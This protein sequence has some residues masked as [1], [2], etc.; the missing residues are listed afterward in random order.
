[1]NQPAVKHIV[2]YLYYSLR[3]PLCQGLMLNYLKDLRSDQTVFHLITFEQEKFSMSPAEAS[4][5]RDQL[6]SGFNIEWHPL[7]YSSGSFFLMKKLF[8]A[9]KA[10]RLLKKIDGAHQ[11]SLVCAM[12]TPVGSY[13]FIASRLYHKKFCQFTFEPHAQIMMESGRISSAGLKYRIGHWLEMMIG[14]NAETVVCTT[15]HMVDNLQKLG[16]KGELFRLPTSVDEDKNRFSKAGRDRLRK[17]L[18]I[19][20]K[21]VLIYP[22]KFGGMYAESKAI[23]VMNAFLQ[24][25][26][27]AHVLI[28]TDHEHGA[29]REWMRSANM[30]ELR[31]TLLPV[32]PLA[33]LPAYL[34]AADIGLVA[35]ADFGARKYCSPVKVGEYLLCG[36]PYIVQ[37]GTSE[38][39]AYA[40]K[41]NVGV[42]LEEFSSAGLHNAITS[43]R[44]LLNEDKS[45]LR[46]RCRQVGEQYRGKKNALRLMKRIF[47]QA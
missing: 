30:P 37:R 33:E 15:R 27:E 7:A 4:L 39:D 14:K 1:M 47:D 12:A 42:V 21:A 43:V 26:P 44:S 8:S 6:L 22:G 9:L 5:E 17:E 38:D 3:D 31:T 13:A 35:Y 25:V 29:I 36:L 41:E 45:V 2:I 46:A 20:D 11:V 34:S 19:E 23:E 18:K 16:A 40:E 28:I 24:N 32:V 10:I